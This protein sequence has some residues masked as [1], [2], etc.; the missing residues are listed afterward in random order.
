MPDIVRVG[1]YRVLLQGVRRIF[2]RHPRALQTE[3]QVGE[4]AVV[5]RD[6]PLVE[7]DG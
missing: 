6:Q 2:G 7:L 5:G 4:A 3:V 1:P